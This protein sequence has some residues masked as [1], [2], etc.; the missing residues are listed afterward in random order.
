MPE[1]MD[2][3]ERIDL[4]GKTFAPRVEKL[5]EP[6]MWLAA[7]FIADRENASPLG[8]MRA[9]TQL[10]FLIWA[11]KLA[12]RERPETSSSSST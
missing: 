4:L 8:A 12:T 2:V 7:R 11:C 5:T 1:I 3:Y 10:A 6:Q 9:D